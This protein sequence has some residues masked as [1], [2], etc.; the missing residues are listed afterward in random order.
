VQTEIVTI[1]GLE[2]DELEARQLAV[3]WEVLQCLYEQQKP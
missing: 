1:S 3:I 2:G